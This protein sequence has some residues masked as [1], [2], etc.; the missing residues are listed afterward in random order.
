MKAFSLPQKRRDC[1]RS[2]SQMT[3]RLKERTELKKEGRNER[4]KEGSAELRT[5]RRT[6]GYSCACLDVPVV[7]ESSSVGAVTALPQIGFLCTQCS[8]VHRCVERFQLS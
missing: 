3:E 2:R 4:T 8:S 5:D 6:C 1:N 7:V